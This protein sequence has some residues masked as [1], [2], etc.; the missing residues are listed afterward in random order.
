LLLD[1]TL[2][3]IDRLTSGEQILN[4]ADGA[5]R[6]LRKAILFPNERDI[7][8]LSVGARSVDFGRSDFIQVINTRRAADLAERLKAVKSN[9]W[10]EGAISRDF[11]LLRSPLLACLELTHITRAILSWRH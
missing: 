6:L 10:R 8:I 2:Q 1:G 5:W 11:E 4:D 9:L 3:Y 7:S